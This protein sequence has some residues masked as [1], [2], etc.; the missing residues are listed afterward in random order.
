MGI[1]LNASEIDLSDPGFWDLP[2]E[3]RFAAFD[4]LRRELPVSRHSPPVAWSP[5]E[6][7]P[8]GAYWAVT[9]HADV[10]AVTRDPQTFIA[11]EGVMLFDN[12]PREVQRL[13]DGFLGLDDP[14]HAQ[15]RRLVSAAFSPRVMRRIDDWITEQA[16]S[17]VAA[18][19]ERGTCD[20]YNDLVRPFPAN[21]ICDMLGVPESDRAEL[22]H[23]MEIGVEFGVGDTTIEDSIAAAHAVIDY[24]AELARHRQQHPTDDLTTALVQAEIDGERLSDADIGSTFWTILTGGSETTGSTAAHG[25]VALSHDPAQRARWQSDFDDH[26]HGAVEE[27]LRWGAPIIHFRRVATR[28]TEIAGQ[29]IE[30]GDNVLIFYQS[31]NR[32]ETVFEDP[33][34]FDIGRSPN[35]HVGFGG[36]GPHHCLGAALA[37][38]ELA[39]FF[40]EVFRLLPDIELSSEPTYTPNPFLDLLETVPCS[41]SPTNATA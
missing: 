26:A 35:P 22:L 24:G 5:A 21:V 20:F 17:C 41:F 9:R 38:T 32:D 4:T 6:Y 40:R 1:A 33:Y 2:R 34:R 31:A 28:D 23:T 13:Y 27:M 3:V 14:R 7:G 11:G 10:C 29:R 36:G 12:L 18:V 19:A 8:P 30:A 16:R 15:I 25:M 39:T 37:R